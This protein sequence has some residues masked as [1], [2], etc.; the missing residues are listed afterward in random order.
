MHYGRKCFAELAVA[1]A[2]DIV[3]FYDFASCS[4]DL[5]HIVTITEKDASDSDSCRSICRRRTKFSAAALTMDVPPH[6]QYWRGG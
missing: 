2:F 4:F 6:K 5:L 3:R 1:K